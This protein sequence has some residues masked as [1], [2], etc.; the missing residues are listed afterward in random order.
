MHGHRSSDTR[1]SLEGFRARKMTLS[2]LSARL[3]TL[4]PSLDLFH[5][6]DPHLQGLRS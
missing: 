2:K 6:G 3:S 4:L 1:F 5:N